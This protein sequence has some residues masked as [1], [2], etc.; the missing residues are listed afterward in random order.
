MY[1]LT[2][3]GKRYLEEGLPEK[4]LLNLL[5]EEG[6]EA[7]VSDLKK[8]MDDFSI[9]VNWSM[10][11]NWMEIKEGKAIL[12][13]S[14]KDFSLKKTLE[15]IRSGEDLEDEERELLLERN[16]IHEIREDVVKKAQKQ[17]EDDEIT[18]LTPELIK[19]GLWRESNLKKY[20]VEK[21]GKE[22]YPGKKQAY[23]AF[24]DEVKERLTDLGFKEMTGP[25]IE[26]EFSN[27]D[28]LF[29]P[30]DHPARGIHDFYYLENPKSGNLN[31]FEKFVQ[32][33]RKVH[34]TGEGANSN[35]WGSTFSKKESRKHILR[36]QGTA[37]SARMLMNEGL[38]IPGK[39]FS[40]AR[41]YR[42]DVVDATH[43][44]E[45]N[46]LEGIVLGEDLNFRNLLGL[47]KKFAKEITGIDKVKFRPGYFP[48]TEP[49]VEGYVYHPKLQEWVEVLPAGVFRKEVTKPLG[50][51]APV[52]AW[53]L[54]VDRLFMIREGIEDIR[55]LFSQDLKWLRG[56]KT[57]QKLI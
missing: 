24:L 20:N 23:R 6:K 40:L 32:K 25:T 7:K 47:L 18:N 39:Y 1:K 46:H 48:F 29:M 17:L 3:E 13:D 15:K 2:K 5:K 9:A 19:T 50:V 45:F 8:K 12:L 27:C 10:K 21:T 34:E 55:K 56:V 4:R 53:G 54:G 35:G 30:Q 42:P 28:A 36:S 44:T 14:P 33:V 52:L 26:K 51:D 43:L 41:C 37:V 16:L 57:C 11:N 22:I 38:E 49:S 31:E